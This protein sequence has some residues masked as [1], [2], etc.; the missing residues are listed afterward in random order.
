VAGRIGDGSAGTRDVD[1]Y[2]V[3]IAAR[4]RLFV[5]VDA[6]SL[7]VSSTLDSYLRVFDSSGRQ[8]ASNDDSGGSLDSYLTF[9]PRSAG[10]YYVGVSGFGN[11][12][13]SATRTASGRTGS[14]G[15]YE[16]ALRVESTV[17]AR[18]LDIRALGMPDVAAAAFAALGNEPAASTTKRG[19]RR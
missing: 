18:S 7:T 10:T 15:G 1:I 19:S 9:T 17:A 4:Q 11:V 14:T 13:Y 8:L 12:S 16:L 3:T 2:R 5:D 6:R